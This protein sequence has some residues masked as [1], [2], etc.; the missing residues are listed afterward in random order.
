MKKSHL[1]IFGIF[2][3]LFVLV[4]P[5]WAIEREGSAGA[6]PEA[7][8]EE[9]EDAKT[10]FQANCGPCHTLAKA[11]TDGVI[12]PNLDDILVAGQPDANY[13]RV[14][15]AIDEGVGGRMPADI[16][17]GEA[18]KQVADFVSRVAGQ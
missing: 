12:G 11:G 6:S 16:L 13:G 15:D 8:A 17:S 14:L 9:Q 1:V 5:F 18:A 10:L 7:V 4:I 2:A 3:A